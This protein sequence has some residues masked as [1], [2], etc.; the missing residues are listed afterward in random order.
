M[1]IVY[2]TVVLLV[3]LFVGSFV[4]YVVFFVLHNNINSLTPFCDKCKESLTLLDYIPIVSVVKNGLTCRNCSNPI[5]LNH[6]VVNIITAV[7][8][9]LLYIMVDDTLLFFNYCLVT[10]CLIVISIVDLKIQE[11]PQLFTIVIGILGALLILLDIQNIQ[12]HILGLVIIPVFLLL[13]LVLSS[14][15][16]VGLGDIKL[17]A[18]IGLLLGWKLSIV[19]FYSGCVLLVVAYPVLKKLGTQGFKT[20]RVPFGPYLCLGAYLSLLVG[21]KIYSFVTGLMFGG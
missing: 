14:G 20:N 16:G 17:E 3:G 18:A 2:A 8:L 12:A 10:F 11:I 21:D 6:L 15:K 7:A 19:A 4:N 9:L 5:H 13:I 1:N